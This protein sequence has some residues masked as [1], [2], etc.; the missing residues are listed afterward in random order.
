MT[1]YRHEYEFA[2]LEGIRYRFHTQPIGVVVEGGQVTGLECLRVELGG[3]DASGR[4][5]PVLVAGSEHVMACDM[6]I[7]AVGQEK[8][9]LAVE[10]GLDIDKGY[11]RVDDEL[12]TGTPRVWAGGDCVRVRGSASTVMAVQD[13]KIAARSI[14]ASLTATEPA[15]HT[16]TFRPAVTGEVNHG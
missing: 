15:A 12:R 13:G 10:L 6:V 1:A 11:I 3:L 9:A 16:L 4:P 14:H 2:L 8:P 7:K 5:T